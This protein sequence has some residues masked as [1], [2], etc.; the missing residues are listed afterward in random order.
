MGARIVCMARKALM[1]ARFRKMLQNMRREEEERKE[2]ERLRIEEQVRQEEEH[3]AA[4]LEIERKHL[5]E[6]RKQ[7]EE[8]LA[9]ERLRQ[10]AEKK[11]RKAKEA[12]EAQSAAKR[13]AAQRVANA[14]IN[15][16]VPAA[17]AKVLAKAAA[18][19][20]DDGP[21]D[22]DYMDPRAP[23]KVK[24]LKGART[25][26]LAQM[27][28][29]DHVNPAQHPANL[30]MMVDEPT[31]NSFPLNLGQLEDLP[32]NAVDLCRYR[33][34]IPKLETR[35]ELDPVYDTSGQVKYISVSS[36]YCR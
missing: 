20:I 33:N 31:F 28:R 26:E 14:L 9:N 18:H 1:R 17:V 11:A 29:S 12:Q 30:V 23:H 6:Q 24:T 15:T 10:E 36:I 7:E 32:P 21:A 27:L 35:V 16:I 8:R 13:V 22:A 5:E 2:R 34:I 4:L 25:D 3:K 19:K